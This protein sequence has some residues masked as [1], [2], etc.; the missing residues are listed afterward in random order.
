MRQFK[1][2]RI[3][4]IEPF[5]STKFGLEPINVSNASPV[6][7][8]SNINLGASASRAASSPVL[9]GNSSAFVGPPSPSGLSSV[10]SPTLQGSSSAFVGPPSPSGLSSVTSIATP[11]QINQAFEDYLGRPVDTPGLEGYLSS[12]KSIDEIRA[13]LA[14]VASQS[15]ETKLASDVK[16]YEAPSDLQLNYIQNLGG[17]IPTFTMPD[18]Y[19]SSIYKAP[20]SINISSKP[21]TA[22]DQVDQQTFDYD[23]FEPSTVQEFNQRASERDDTGFTTW[24]D[25]PN[26]DPAE[27]AA[28]QSAGFESP[29]AYFLAKLESTDPSLAS[30]R[31]STRDLIFGDKNL[32]EWRDEFKAPIDRNAE[33]TIYQELKTQYD[34]AAEGGYKYKH[35]S[36]LDEIFRSEA[37][38]LA[39][40][41]VK[42]IY[43]IGTRE[44]DTFLTLSKGNNTESGNRIANVYKRGDDYFYEVDEGEGPNT[45]IKIDPDTITNVEEVLKTDFDPEGGGEYAYTELQ[46]QVKDKPIVELINKNTGDP[47]YDVILQG[48]YREDPTSYKFRGNETIDVETR[49]GYERIHYNTKV[50]DMAD[51][52]FQMISDGQGNEIPFMVPVFK[53]T[54]TDLTPVAFLASAFL[55]PYA[56]QIGSAL[57]ATT[58]AGQAAIGAGVISGGTQLVVNGKIDPLRLGVS[59][60]TAGLAQ[61]GGFTG[62]DI[63]ADAAQLAEQGLSSAQI[64]DTLVASGVNSV[65]ANLAGNFASAGISV[66]IAPMITAGTQN[67]G[68]TA[69]AMGELNADALTKSFLTGASW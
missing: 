19:T 39:A 15:P 51:Y 28:A 18:V 54:K 2:D 32:F 57:G 53:S 55:G 25:I 22:A 12:G 46:V 29:N 59:M 50:R 26:V 47:L 30:W 6:A 67:M 66:E 1:T 49:R 36:D 20:E 31:E 43:D 64:A 34:L 5:T 35:E 21:K 11:V 37:A 14:Y 45:V 42:S 4:D 27:I 56:M 69:L 24:E 41:G 61:T 9:Q 16:Y 65:T 40:G 7:P 62:S 8:L 23:F 58:M 44:T 10:A 17:G 60:V 63:A 13:D 3:L 48:N 68:L 52:S 38:K 33:E